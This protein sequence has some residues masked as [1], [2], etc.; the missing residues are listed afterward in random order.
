LLDW[1]EVDLG[2]TELSFIQIDLCV[3]CVFDT[4]VPFR[5]RCVDF[6]VRVGKGVCVCVC[7]CVCVCVC[8]CVWI[9]I[10]RYTSPP[11]ACVYIYEACVYIYEA[12]V[13]I[14]EACLK[15]YLCVSVDSYTDMVI[16]M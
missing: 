8:V 9:F 6:F 3:L 13:Y 7:G 2:F 14:Y 12:C 1:F 4:Q 10:R 5:A 15:G 16:C 11:C